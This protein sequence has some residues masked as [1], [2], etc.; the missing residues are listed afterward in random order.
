MSG[1]GAFGDQR[2][3]ATDPSTAVKPILIGA[4]FTPSSE[5]IQRISVRSVLEDAAGATP[6]IVLNCEITIMAPMPHEKP[7]TTACGTFERCR[8]NRSTQNIIMNTEATIVTFAAPPMPCSLTASAMNGTV[9]LAVPPMRTGFLPSRAVAGAVTIEVNKPST[10]GN[11]ISEAIAKP[12][13][14]AISAAMIPPQTSPAS[15]FQLYFHLGLLSM[16][17]GYAITFRNAVLNFSISS[18]VPIETR[19]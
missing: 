13:G 17:A 6:V 4:S 7:A 2:D 1:A 10:G 18:L 16:K 5:L 9:A 15:E 12:Y 19:T 14:I 8:P 11:P 3:A